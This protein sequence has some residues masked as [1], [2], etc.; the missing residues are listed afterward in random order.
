LSLKNGTLERKSIPL[1]ETKQNQDNVDNSTK[2][3]NGNDNNETNDIINSRF[4]L[5]L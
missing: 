1:P 2:K 4:M 3:S 5:P